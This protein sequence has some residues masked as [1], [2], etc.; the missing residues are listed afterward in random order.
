[1]CAFIPSVRAWALFSTDCVRTLRPRPAM[2]AGS[3]PSGGW[4]IR[5]T[6]MSTFFLHCAMRSNAV[7]QCASGAAPRS[8]ARTLSSKICSKYRTD[9]ST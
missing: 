6:A 1:M 2:P 7:F 5:L 3:I 4:S 8:A 9:R